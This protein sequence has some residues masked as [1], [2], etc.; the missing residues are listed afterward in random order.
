MLVGADVGPTRIL[1]RGDGVRASLTTADETVELEGAGST[2]WVE[3]TVDDVTL[4]AVTLGDEVAGPDFAIDGGL[5]RVSR[6]DL[7]GRSAGG[8]RRGRDGPAPGVVIEPETDSQPDT[9]PQPV[10]EPEA[11]SG[12][13]GGG[14]RPSAP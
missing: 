6:I 10:A 13:P 7:P 11:G 4:L 12:H 1:L 3:R 9:A 5:V 14:A 8:G 2:T